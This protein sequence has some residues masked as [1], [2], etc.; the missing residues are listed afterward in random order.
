M[1]DAIPP[2]TFRIEPALR[3]AYESIAAR[4]DTD[5][6]DLSLFFNNPSYFTTDSHGQPIALA[7]SHPTL[8]HWPLDEY[9]GGTSLLNR[10]AQECRTIQAVTGAATTWVDRQYWH[11]T[12]FSPVHSSDP[13]VIARALTDIGGVV[14]E[15]VRQTRSYSLNFTRILVMPDGGIK[16]V[17]YA[18]SDELTLLRRKL[19]ELVPGGGA[20]KLI[21]MSLGSFVRAPHA[22]DL[23]NLQTYLHR[24]R[25]DGTPLG[26][27]VVRYLTYAQYTG[28]FTN[29]TLRAIARHP[30]LA[31]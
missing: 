2:S 23:A 28:P 20:P 13:Q 4:F 1:S 7:G 25:N 29:M 5:G 27:I 31:A 16:A 14:R 6:I 3:E 22:R 21:H 11:S 30:L 17:A 15:E 12:V 26:R 9:A 10:L 19:S 8:V 18:S 24:F